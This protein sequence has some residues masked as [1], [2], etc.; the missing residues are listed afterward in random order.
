MPC[1]IASPYQ[2]RAGAL[3][4]CRHH[5]R[6]Q[7]CKEPKFRNFTIFEIYTFLK[8]DHIRFQTAIHQAQSACSDDSD[9]CTSL[10]ISKDSPVDPAQTAASI[11]DKELSRITPTPFEPNTDWFPDHIETDCRDCTAFPDLRIVTKFLVYRHHY[12]YTIRLY[13]A[14]QLIPCDRPTMYRYYTCMQGSKNR[15]FGKPKFPKFWKTKICKILKFCF[16]T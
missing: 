7:T 11:S 13:T 4:P 16:L 5:M 14:K 6:S 9:H 10:L 2:P 8:F 12:R 15:N 3:P 1:A